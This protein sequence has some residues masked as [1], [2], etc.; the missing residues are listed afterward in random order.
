MPIIRYNHNRAARRGANQVLAAV[1]ATL[2]AD[3]VD[4]DRFN[5]YNNLDKV[6]ASYRN[7]SA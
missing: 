5:N 4:T 6:R 7:Y 1:A 2:D 3:L